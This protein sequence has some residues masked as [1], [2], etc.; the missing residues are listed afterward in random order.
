MIAFSKS[1]EVMKGYKLRVWDIYLAHNGVAVGKVHKTYPHGSDPK[2]H[3]EVIR[4]YGFRDVSLC[5]AVCHLSSGKEIHIKSYYK[6]LSA[7]KSVA[8]AVFADR[9]TMSEVLINQLS[10]W[11]EKATDKKWNTKTG[12]DNG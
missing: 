5:D 6:T 4:A 7:A 9:E 11:V 10:L 2:Y 3:I 1:N 8:R 12:A